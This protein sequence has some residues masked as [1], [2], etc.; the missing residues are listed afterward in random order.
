[1]AHELGQPCA[2]LLARCIGVS[3]FS[4]RSLRAFHA[5]CP[6]RAAA[7]MAARMA[8]RM[9]HSCGL[10]PAARQSVVLNPPAPR[11]GDLH[12]ERVVAAQPRPGG[13]A[14]CAQ[15]PPGARAEAMNQY[16]LEIGIS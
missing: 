1:M 14:G 12:P 5:I 7:R 3:E 6:V 10:S 9:T 16:V 15:G 4:P 11:P 13:R 8:V 2:I